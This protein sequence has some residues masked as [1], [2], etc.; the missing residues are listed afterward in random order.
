MTRFRS[1]IELFYERPRYVTRN[2]YRKLFEILRVQLTNFPRDHYY[3][4]NGD[5]TIRNKKRSF[6]VSMRFYRRC[7][8]KFLRP[9]TALSL[10]RLFLRP[11]KKS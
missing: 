6:L 7:L 8:V 3:D 11:L 5:K 2:S 9:R 10:L 1:V 4:V